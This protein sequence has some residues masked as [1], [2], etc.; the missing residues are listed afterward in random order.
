M[1][2]NAVE[3][4]RILRNVRPDILVSSL[5]HNNIAALLAGTLS[6]VGTRVFVCQHNFLSRERSL[7]WKYYVVPLLYRLLSRGA[8]GMI[9]VSDGV[10]ADLAATAGIRRSRITTIFNPV[11]GPD[12]VTRAAGPAPH[13]WLA[14]REGQV[15]VFV[16]RLVDQKDPQTLL[17]GFA[18]LR[19]SAARLIL[20][21]DGPLRQALVAL[22]ARLGIDGRVLFAGHQ[23]NPLPWI[24][25]ADALVLTSR[26]EGFGNVI[27]EALACGT[28]VI[29]TDCCAGPAEILDQPGYG[30]LIAPGDARALAAAMAAHRKSR[31][32]TAIMRRRADMFS[33]ER[34]ADRH[35]SLFQSKRLAGCTIFGLQFIRLH[36]H[37]IV[38][39]VIDSAPG[40]GVR[41]VVT[42]NADHIRLLRQSAFAAAC[43]S[44]DIVCADG[45]PVA[46]YA[47]ARGLGMLSRVTGCDILHLLLADEELRRHRVLLVAESLRTMRAWNARYGTARN[48]Q[49]LLAPPRLLQDEG[50]QM[51]LARQAGA[52]GATILIMALGAPV[53]EIFIHRQRGILPPCWALCV[54]QAARVELGLVG[55]A[56]PMFRALACEWL[57]RLV[58]EPRRMAAR[59]FKCM[60]WFPV[61]VARDMLA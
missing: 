16:G 58:Q 25:Y 26:Y 11:I 57:W 22:A 51:R 24:L 20:L 53:S 54:G 2:G 38:R 44:A 13:R 42:P 23:L 28:P 37:Q 12:F 48:M 56:P 50:A 19:N 40:D 10:A 17:H 29:A 1:L 47:W 43:Q 30:T 14:S 46:L 32:S 6:L 27:V 31:F 9:A 41:L 60:I 8:T 21:G 59:Y 61:A 52:C 45:F 7:G 5:D 18:M 36:A 39:H 33:V 35:V 4:A 15:F 3:L 49:A 55:R 34:C